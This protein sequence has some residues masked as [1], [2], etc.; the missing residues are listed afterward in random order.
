MRDHLPNHFGQ[1]PTEILPQR[2][3]AVWA[4]V[5]AAGIF[6]AGCHSTP[7]FQFDALDVAPV[8]EQLAEFSLGQ[9]AIPVPVR[10]KEDGDISQR[11]NRVELEFALY[12]LVSPSQVKHLADHWQRHQGK[13]RDRVIFVCRS[14][15]LAELSEP[16]MVTLKTRLTDAVR[17]QIGDREIRRL[18]VSEMRSQEI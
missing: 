7:P 12:A 15:S 16:D 11:S 2:R 6:G 8:Q 10:A 17:A 4:A 9:Y 3:A 14:A 13:I 1:G 5:C 18:L